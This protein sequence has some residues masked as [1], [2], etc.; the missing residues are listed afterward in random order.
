MSR[1]FAFDDF[2]RT[3][4]ENSLDGILISNME[5][6][7]LDMNPA[8]EGISGYVRA[9]AFG[10][11]LYEFIPKEKQDEIKERLQRV[12]TTVLDQTNYVE[13]FHR[14]GTVKVVETN[15]IKAEMEGEELVVTFIRDI[16]DWQK[17]AYELERQKAFNALVIKSMPGIFYLQE[18]TDEDEL[19]LVDW[20]DNYQEASGLEPEQL[21]RLNTMVFFS[22]EEQEGIRHS[23]GKIR[24]G[25]T[26][27]TQE[28]LNPKRADGRVMRYFFQ[29]V[30]FI[31][32]G[33]RYL[34]G[35]GIDISDKRDLEQKLIE[36]VI[37]TE[38]SERRR[39]S[40]ELHDGLG[41]EL[42]TIKLYLQG[43]LDSKD[44]TERKK[45][46]GKLLSMTDEAVVTISD[47]AYNIS[48]RLLLENGLVAAIDSFLDR[49][50]AQCS[51][52]FIREF[53]DPGRFDINQEVTV[54]RAVIELI[55]NTLKH[56]SAHEVHLEIRRQTEFLEIVYKD[57]GNG[58]DMGSVRKHGKGF[59]LNNMKS[60]LESHEGRCSFESSLGKGMQARIRI[61]LR[62]QG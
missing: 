5:G 3:L 27:F 15:D 29:S 35:S 38:E 7:I 28:I 17:M 43:L 40:S 37:R 11:S 48:P 12:H 55:N 25:E 51:L 57:D 62:S 32:E 52:E 44:E 13:F 16:T 46:G 56:A 36:S 9:E 19:I 59:G 53:Q 50:Q 22:P 24:R 10:R 14:S 47:I 4:F 20:N 58:F 60:R 30:S 45:I 21:Y 23:L 6:V 42:S 49:L 2:F 31:R 54:Y 33:K 1:E 39:I 18:L 61:P 8:M 26:D 41:A 34:L